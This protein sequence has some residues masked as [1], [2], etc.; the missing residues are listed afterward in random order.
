MHGVTLYF[1]VFDSDYV[2]NSVKW[3]VSQL[4]DWLMESDIHL[5]PCH[6]HEES[7]GKSE[8]LDIPSK[9]VLKAF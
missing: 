8:N 9:V 5:I 3:T 4:I 2:K 7:L 1:E 6:V